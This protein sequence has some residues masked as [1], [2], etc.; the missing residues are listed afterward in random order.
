MNKL[1]AALLSTLL[2]TAPLAQAQFSVNV[3]AIHVN[4]ID[5][6]SA[7]KENTALGLSADSDTQLGITFDYQYN[8]NIVFELIAAT[9]F[10]HTVEGQGGLAGNDIAQVKHLPPTLLA[11]YH[12]FG[13]GD[14]FRP[15]VGV[16]LN[17]TVFF[18]EEA[19]AALKQTLKTDDVKVDL[20][21]SFGVALQMGFN[22]DINEK[23]GLH[24]MVSKMD[25]DTDATVYA[26]GVQALTSD[27]EIDPFVAMIGAKYKF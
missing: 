16:G 6:A 3:G 7:I 10:S 23:W 4:P 11:Q 13:A 21:S 20:D 15:F 19:S 26:N 8:D 2:V 17:Y 25:I 12:F 1:T 9:P 18:D 14:K 27:V 5:S 24:V 22:Y